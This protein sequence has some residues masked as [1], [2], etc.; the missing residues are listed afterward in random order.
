[1]GKRASDN[2]GGGKKE[3]AEIMGR[4]KVEPTFSRYRFFFTLHFAFSRRQEAFTFLPV[5]VVDG[6]KIFTVEGGKLPPPP[7]PRVGTTNFHNV[8]HAF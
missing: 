8:R 7:P 2:G 4:K 1:L 6:T 5:V 3:K